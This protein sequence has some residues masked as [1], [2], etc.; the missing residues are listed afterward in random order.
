[1]GLD[2]IRVEWSGLR[3]RIQIGVGTSH[4]NQPETGNYYSTPA[5]RTHFSQSSFGHVLVVP[6]FVCFRSD[7]LA[8][9]GF[10]IWT[11]K[12]YEH[13]CMHI[14]SLCEAYTKWALWLNGSELPV[15]M[16][17][18]QSVIENQLSLDVVTT[19]E[20]TC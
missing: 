1:M 3:V 20:Q 19:D 7:S 14:C 11:P 17:R 10:R 13:L 5:T 9:H 18:Y 6:G 15:T 8:L 12:K 2:C 4:A 16:E